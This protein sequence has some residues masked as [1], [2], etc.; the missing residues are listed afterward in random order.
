MGEKLAIEGGK[1]AVT[2]WPARGLL[3]QAEKKAVMKLF[4]EAITSGNAI[5]Y[6]GPEEEAYC[7]EFAEFLGGG[8]ADAV[9]SG[10]SAVYVALRT[11]QPKAFSEVVCGPVS[12]PGGIM[13]IAL[14]GCIPIIAD[15]EPG[16]FNMS[17]KS[18]ARRITKRT[19][20]IIVAHIAGLPAD[21][22]AIMKIA[23]AKKIPVI[24]DCAQ[25]HGAKYKGKY[26]GTIGDVGAFSTMSGKHHCTG[27]QGGVVFVKSEELYWRARRCSDRGKPF[28]V[29]GNNG[30][31]LAS[32]N[33][34]LNDL[35]ACIGRVQLKKLPQ[36]IAKRRK[37]AEWL[38]AACKKELKAVRI[39]EALPNTEPVYW[40][41]FGQFDLKK[42]KVDK[43]AFCKALQAEG[44]PVGVSYLHLFTAQDWYTQR[45]VFEGTEY[46]WTSPLYKGNPDRKYP[47]PNVMATDK[48][49][50]QLPWHE[51]VTISTAKQIL[52]AFKKLETA[53]LK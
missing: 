6:N 36:I 37:T 14:A 20:A 53:Y 31:V 48:Y 42:L 46:P 21:M 52:K 10:T 4:D 45:R 33:L 3:G 40:F 47:V 27:G 30:N 13:P 44:M 23:H 39:A 7:S 8:Y 41:L 26:V 5:G 11:V 38:I 18:L 24:E 50:V 49:T 19:S 2:S 35:S 28:G 51:S 32:H 25:C 22:D 29:T 1:Q 9:N 15:A 17:P 16:S 12:D 34:N 43:A